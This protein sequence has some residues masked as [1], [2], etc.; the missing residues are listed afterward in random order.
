MADTVVLKDAALEAII[1]AFSGK[2]PVAR[3]GILGEQ[4]ARKPA[5][6]PAEISFESLMRRKTAD[7]IAGPPAEAPTNAEVG[8]RHEYGTSKMPA[9]S[10]L[11]M[12][13]NDRLW[14]FLYRA[15][16]FEKDAIEKV[17]KTK[18]LRPYIEKIALSGEQC[19][20]EAF[21]TGG[22]GKWAPWKPGYTNN[23]GQ[24]LVDS[25]QLRN[26]IS[27]EVK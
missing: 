8:A 6:V 23:T 22:F 13:I 7:Q 25:Q 12:P 27:S 16:A 21:K 24:I 19:V 15:G 3:V 26:S 10:F 17:I 20:A 9:R 1:K 11:R 14:T 2:I 4:G 5:E 18:T